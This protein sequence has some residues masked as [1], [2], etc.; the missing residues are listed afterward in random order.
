[1]RRRWS[2]VVMVAC[3]VPVANPAARAEGTPQEGPVDRWR[4][5]LDAAAAEQSNVIRTGVGSTLAHGGPAGQRRTAAVGGHGTYSAPEMS[6][7]RWV[8]AV[9]VEARTDTPTGTAAPTGGVRTP[10]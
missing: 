8:S 10:C 5:R 6:A 3:A 2:A 4:V 1:M 7:G 9:R